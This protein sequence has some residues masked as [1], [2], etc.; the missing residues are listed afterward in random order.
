[1]ALCDQLET[2]H[3]NAAEAHEKLVSHLLATLTHS[4]NAEDFAAC[5]QRIAAHFDT[6][7][8]TE[9]SI[10][11]LKQT[12][13]QLAVM[14]KLVPQDKNDEPASVLLEQLA[15]DAK[16]YAAKRKIGQ[17]K[18]EPISAADLPSFAP[19]GWMWTRLCSIFRIIT[20]GDHLSP[21]QVEDGVAFLTIGNITTGRLEFSGCRFV[22][23]DYFE[24]VASY[25]R[26]EF[27]DIL[28]TVVGAT[29]GR[30]VFV[31]SH[32]KFCVQRHIA[33]LKCS[34]H[35]DVKF[36]C[37]LLSSPDVYKQATQC[38]TGTAQPTIPLRPLRN[39]LILLPPLAEQH[40]IVAKVDELMALCDRLKSRI[41][42]A[43][44]LQQKLADV[45][46][47][48]AAA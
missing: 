11:V 2:R 12:L 13:L 32:Q 44:R 29:Y 41:A 26:P 45:L 7:F 27:G 38:T 8:T 1:M 6:L 9:N 15:D 39:F 46:V 34:E 4:Q 16:K 3:G 5:W 23:S 21:P 40:R 28:Y 47:E 25:R 48:Q 43:S 36:A 31:D 20:D 24:S 19:N 17:P 33:I 37:H 14:G 35:L 22:P 18:P 30:P 42:D 10:D